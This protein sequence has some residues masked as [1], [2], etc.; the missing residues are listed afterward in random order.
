MNYLAPSIL[1]ADFCELGKQIQE[2]EKAGAQYLHFDIMDGMFVPSISFGMPVL[3]SI[4][5]CTKMFVDAHMMVMQP[6]RYIEDLAK[7][8]ADG[9][10]IHVEA[11]DCIEE[12]LKKIR[13]LGLKAGI[14]INPPTPVEKVIP[15]IGMA[16]MVLVMTVNPGFGG[17]K[18]IPECTD[19][20]REIRKVIDEKYPEV[21]L[22]IDGGVNLD[23]LE[24]NLEAGANVIVAG[25]AVF[26][27]DIT[28][29]TSKFLK[30]ME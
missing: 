25:S 26:K 2:T 30:I 19:K 29:N 3:A 16:D 28:E 8:G 1:A 13:E 7:S 27:G 21:L 17:Q 10:T 15:Y 4:K 5:P 23:N 6:E 9:I 18:Y 24:M 20:I 22:Q 12:T 11:C 14:A